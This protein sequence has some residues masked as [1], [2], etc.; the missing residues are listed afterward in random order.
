MLF[1]RQIEVRERSPLLGPLHPD[2]L[3]ARSKLGQTLVEMGKFFEAIPLLRDALSAMDGLGL[4]SEHPHLWIVHRV[5][6]KALLGAGHPSEAVPMF[7]RSIAYT[8]SKHGIH[9][10]T[11]PPDC[12][13]LAKAL[14]QMGRG[15]DERLPLLDRAVTIR[16]LSVGRDKDQDA[17]QLAPHCPPAWPRYCIPGARATN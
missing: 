14:G 4:G 11:I 6:G 3:G 2:T 5:Y 15:F 16:E 10:S 13:R 17:R 9:Y 8:E 12:I 1:R 7:Q